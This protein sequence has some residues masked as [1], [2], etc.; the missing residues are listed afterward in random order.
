M[1]V[2][3]PKLIFSIYFSSPES[4]DGSQGQTTGWRATST[5]CY[6]LRHK[7]KYLLSLV[8][9][10]SAVRLQVT[11]NSIQSS[12]YIYSALLRCMER[13]SPSLLV[14]S[15]EP[16]ITNVP[17]LQFKFA[18]T[19]IAQPCTL[20]GGAHPSFAHPDYYVWILRLADVG[21]QWVA[22]SQVSWPLWDFLIDT[23]AL[24]W[25]NF[26]IHQINTFAFR[27]PV[28]IQK[29]KYQL[30]V[31]TTACSERTLGRHC[32]LLCAGLGCWFVENKQRKNMLH[33]K[34][35]S[36]AAKLQVYLEPWRFPFA[37]GVSMIKRL[38]KTLT[39]H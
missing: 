38:K 5:K 13:L 37:A 22:D 24:G 17:S 23:A 10:K 29:V 30:E 32:S 16:P 34:E 28:V 33:H 20:A 3:Y 4:C 9:S 19:F 21:R 25:S 7:W 31:S 12:S 14:E 27:P 1:F 36:S 39:G 6:M 8:N 26:I 35:L 11:E 18:W 2:R 15:Y